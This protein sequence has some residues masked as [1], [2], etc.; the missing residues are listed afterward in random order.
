MPT[1]RRRAAG[2][3]AARLLAAGEVMEVALAGR[4]DLIV[5]NNFKDFVSYRTDVREPER[6][7]LH[8]AAD[9]R[10]IVAQLFTAAQ[11]FREGRIVIP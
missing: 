11:W 8:G 4:A 1:G 5:T 2:P 9:A 3:G 7:A 6:I 10:V